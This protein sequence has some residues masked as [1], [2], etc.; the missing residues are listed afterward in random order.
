MS[1]ALTR[2]EPVAVAALRPKSLPAMVQEEILRLILNG[3]LGAGAKLNEVELAAQ[4]GVS[5]GPVRE[6]FRALEEAGLVRL[7]PNRGVFVREISAREAKEIYQVR[8]GLDELAG[9]LLAPVVTETQLAELRKLVQRM[10]RGTA[11]HDIDVYYPLN[12]RFHDRVVEMTGNAK[13]VATYRR[14]IHELHLLRRRG[15]VAGGGLAVS[16]TE[17]AAII[18]ALAT[19]DAER[20]AAA[21]RTHVLAGFQRFHA[22]VW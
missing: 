15:L 5:R 9:R 12:L 6:A 17:H 13:L 22:T 21:M 8:A 10:A 11:A 2:S 1:T 16:N 4:L 18:D 3:R 19:R 20:A 7:A 14:L